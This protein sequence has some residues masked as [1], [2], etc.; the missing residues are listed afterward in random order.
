M[1]VYNSSP[2]TLLE[3]C[4]CRLSIHMRRFEGVRIQYSWTFTYNCMSFCKFTW[5]VTSVA[6]FSKVIKKRHLRDHHNSDD[7]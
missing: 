7:A 6:K 3:Y 2:L 1:H 4:F 5:R